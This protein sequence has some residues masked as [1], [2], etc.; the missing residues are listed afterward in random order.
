MEKRPS[1]ISVDYRMSSNAVA[2]GLHSRKELNGQAGTLALV[3]K[4]CLLK[5]PQLPLDG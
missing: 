3:P 5:Y 4:K 2:H 1:G